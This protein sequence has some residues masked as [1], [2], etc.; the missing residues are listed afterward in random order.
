MEQTL[1]FS[2]LFSFDLVE[3][4]HLSQANFL[5]PSLVLLVNPVYFLVV[6]QGFT[7]LGIVVAFNKK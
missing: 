6:I 4:W 5:Y 2:K 1:T 7:L 3:Q